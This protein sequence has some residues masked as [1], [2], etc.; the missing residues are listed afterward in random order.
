M[1]LRICFQTFKHLQ[2]C[3][4]VFERARGGSVSCSCTR[5]TLVQLNPQQQAQ[6]QG[7]RMMVRIFVYRVREINNKKTCIQYTYSHKEG[8]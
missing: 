2:C 4:L 6:I 5:D 8:G 3:A 7:D 1:I